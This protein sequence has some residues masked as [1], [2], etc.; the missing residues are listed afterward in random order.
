MQYRVSTLTGLIVHVPLRSVWIAVLG[1]TAPFTARATELCV[2]CKG[3]DAVYSCIV[4]NGHSDASLDT[5]AKFYCITKL[6]KAGSHASCAIDRSASPPCPG[7]RKEL[8]IPAFLNGALEDHAEP[9]STSTPS[10]DRHNGD[11]HQVAAPPPAGQPD[12]LDAAHT[13]PAEQ[14]PPENPPRTVQEMVEKGAKSAGDGL[15]E[16]QKTA[17]DAAKS[18]STALEKAGSA[19]GGAAKSSWKCLSSFFSHC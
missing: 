8:P 4:G 3:P 5:V 16:T 6:A 18:A 19:V 14:P 9:Q 15:S 12:Q 11:A 17:G 1:M 2:K 13:Q 7:E 10:V